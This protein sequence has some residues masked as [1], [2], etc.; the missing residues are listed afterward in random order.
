M[1]R[2]RDIRGLH[3]DQP[4]R[5][6]AAQVVAVRAG[7]M[8]AHRKGVLDLTDVERVHAM[9]IATRRLRAALE[10]FGPC[11]PA[12]S[13]RKALRDVKRLADALGER[14]DRDVQIESLEALTATVDDPEREA[15]AFAV[16]QLRAEQRR[17]NRA[18][19]RALRDAKRSG[20]RRRL[21]RLAR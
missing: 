20:L 12:R 13:H 18:L 2:T 9:R 11:F 4:Y 1:P 19:R 7:E 5:R 21:R 10:V 14:R 8:F 6:A 3:P 17:A 16:G 15:I